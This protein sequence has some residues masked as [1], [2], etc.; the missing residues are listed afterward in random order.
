M[1]LKQDASTAGLPR[2]A[3]IA[4]FHEA[5]RDLVE[6]QVDSL[7]RQ[8]GVALRLIGVLDGAKTAQ[9]RELTGY[10]ERSGFILIRN[11]TPLGAGAAFARGL[12]FAIETSEGEEWFSYCDQD[13]V[14]HAGKLARSLACLQETS[15]QLVHCDARVIDEEGRVI[16]PSLHRYERRQEPE[17]LHQHLLLNAVTGMTSLFTAQTAR[18]AVRLI[19]ANTTSILHDHVTAAAAASLGRV[20]FLPEPLVDYI[21][22]DRNQVGANAYDPSARR[23]SFGL[24][25]LRAY[26]AKS[27]RMFEER[28]AVAAALAREGALPQPLATMFVIQRT[29]LARLAATY[30]RAIARLLAHGQRRRAMLCIRMMDAAIM[31]WFTR[32]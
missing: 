6:R 26:R 12:A 20:E 30:I 4:A 28:R 8:Q 21:Q 5:G 10:L 1:A 11:D 7:L 22:H 24:R 18:L 17:D 31:M 14:W 16:A 2:V 3:V 15:A 25:H 29:G 23:R 32:S 9:D 27:C 19:E 13:D